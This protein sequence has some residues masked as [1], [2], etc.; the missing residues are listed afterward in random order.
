M[1]ICIPD[2]LE[3]QEVKTVREWMAASE[4]VD[5]RT[6]AGFRAKRV[7]NNEQIGRNVPSRERID[8]IGDPRLFLKD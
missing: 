3:P 2:V 8:D 6:T 4:F 5:G 1:L 7:K